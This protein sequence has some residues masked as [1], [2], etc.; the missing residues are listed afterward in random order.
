MICYFGA[1]LL[2]VI[3][4]L[5]SETRPSD[6]STTPSRKDPPASMSWFSVMVDKIRGLL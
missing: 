5:C 1:E 4:K 3:Q 2:L 6:S